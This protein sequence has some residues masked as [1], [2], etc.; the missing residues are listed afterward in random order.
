MSSQCVLCPAT[1]F[2]CSVLKPLDNCAR[3][4]LFLCISISDGFC[5]PPTPSSSPPPQILANPHWSSIKCWHIYRFAHT[6]IWHTYAYICF[7]F[8]WRQK[9]NEKR[10]KNIKELFPL[11]AVLELLP[12]NGLHSFCF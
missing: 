9:I 11:I 2:P 1:H 6:Y 3:E 4:M 8:L 5:S 10:Q 7:F 12:E